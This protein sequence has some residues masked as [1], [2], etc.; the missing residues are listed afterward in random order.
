MRKKKKKRRRM[1]VVVV[2]EEA[3]LTKNRMYHSLR[4]MLEVCVS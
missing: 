3:D 2:V 4:V 1:V